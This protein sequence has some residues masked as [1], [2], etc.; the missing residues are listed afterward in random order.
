MKKK[1]LFFLTELALWADLVIELPYPS[2]CLSVC[3]RHRETPTSGC[4]GVFWSCSIGLLCHNFQ[5][6][7]CVRFFWDC[8]EPRIWT[9]LLSIVGELAWEGLWWWLLAVCTSTALQWHLNGASTALKW[10][11]KKII[12]RILLLLSALVK[13]FSVFLKPDFLCSLSSVLCN[14]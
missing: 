10:H 9:I 2:V 4:R 13:R 7:K 11:Q 12:K 14:Y 5:R 8:K 6:K 1:R 3:L